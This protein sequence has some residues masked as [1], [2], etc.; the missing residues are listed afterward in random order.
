MLVRVDTSSA[1]AMPKS[2]TRTSPSPPDQDVLR[3]DVA[4]HEAKL[5]V[6][7]FAQLMGGMQFREPTLA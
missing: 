7:G 3:G 1:L 4:V 2:V 6:T 5:L